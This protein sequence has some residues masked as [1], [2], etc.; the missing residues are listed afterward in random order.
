MLVSRR[1]AISVVIAAAS[2]LVLAL[3]FIQDL[4]PGNASDARAFTNDRTGSVPARDVVTTLNRRANELARG[5][6]RKPFVIP[7]TV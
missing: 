6:Y 4:A 5:T 2:A 1:L 7:E 3:V